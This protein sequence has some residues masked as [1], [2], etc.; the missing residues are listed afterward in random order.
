MWFS[1][2]PYLQVTRYGACAVPISLSKWP[3]ADTFY[4]SGHT[5]NTQAKNLVGS[6]HI[7]NSIK[8]FRVKRGRGQV[9]MTYVLI[10]DSLHITFERVYDRSVL[11]KTIQPTMN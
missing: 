1:E 3:V 8:Y 4:H 5:I 7:W 10:S 11:A 9:H 6:L 2:T